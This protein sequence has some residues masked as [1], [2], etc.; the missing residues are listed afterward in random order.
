M[1]WY[2]LVALVGLISALGIIGLDTYKRGQAIRA[3]REVEATKVI[4][5]V[6]LP[7][8]IQLFEYEGHLYLTR[9]RGG[10]THSESCEAQYHLP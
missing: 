9:F 4:K 8:S 5:T 1:K 2:Q 10:I 3:E 7:K 6:E